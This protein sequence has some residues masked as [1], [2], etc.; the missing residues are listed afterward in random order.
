M[1]VREIMNR[2]TSQNFVGLKVVIPK[3]KKSPYAGEKKFLRFL[4]LDMV[5]LMDSYVEPPGG[6]NLIL[7][8]VE[9][10]EFLDWEACPPEKQ[11]L[12]MIRDGDRLFIDGTAYGRSDGVRVVVES[13]KEGDG[14]PYP[15]SIRFS[16]G[17][18]GQC[19]LSEVKA[20]MRG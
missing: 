17:K 5:W 11:K 3:S 4:S 2:V 10:D 19:K 15:I 9:K 12:P 14:S 20:V 16:D 6:V 7:V 18:P 8:S 1:R 13:V